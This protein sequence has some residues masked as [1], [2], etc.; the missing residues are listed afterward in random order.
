MQ[1]QQRL[2]GTLSGDKNEIL[3]SQFGVN[4]NN[5]PEIYRKGTV[6]VKKSRS[7]RLPRKTYAKAKEQLLE[8][9]SLNDNEEHIMEMYCDI[10]GDQFWNDYPHL[11]G[12]AKAVGHAT[13][14]VTNKSS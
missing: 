6:L 5:E 2:S 9:E 11:M 4:Y 12:D 13:S 1:A 3:F 8:S 7:A 14:K 10:I